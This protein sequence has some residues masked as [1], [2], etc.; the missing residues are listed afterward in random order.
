MIERI[1]GSSSGSIDVCS[2]TLGN[3]TDLLLCRGIDCCERFRSL[4]EPIL[5]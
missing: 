4:Q 2:V 3:L 5:H 1:P